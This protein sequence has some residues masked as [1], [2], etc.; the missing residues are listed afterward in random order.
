MVTDAFFC[1]SV[2]L[3]LL[4]LQPVHAANQTFHVQ[5][6]WEPVHVANQTFH[7][8]GLWEP[9]QPVNQTFLV[10][11]GGGTPR[12]RRSPTPRRRRSETSRRRRTSGCQGPYKHHIH[13]HVH[14]ILSK[15]AHKGVTNKNA[16]DTL[17]DISF[18]FGSRGIPEPRG[19]VRYYNDG[20]I[21]MNH[22]S[23]S[24]WGDYLQC[25]HPDGSTT[26]SCKCPKDHK[27][28]CDMKRAGK[29]QNSH[30]DGHLWYSFPNAG[31]G[32]YW[33][34]E[35]GSGCKAIRVTAKCVIDRLATEA[36][37]PGK[38]STKT[39]TACVTCV[40]K[41]SDK[42]KEHVWDE[43]VFGGKCKHVGASAPPGYNVSANVSVLAANIIV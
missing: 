19:V 43:S 36:G 26:Y 22:M 11:K 39:A 34:Y 40:N 30:S 6:L 1:K 32:T 9:V 13:L 8:Q 14:H 7:V 35:H 42:K 24:S 2:G 4:C 23:V 16:A 10:Q 12:R 31:K 33:D 37:C 17:G 28:S 38:C 15:S 27:G 25:N 41:L 20:V 3:I 29:Q 21:E 18:I 5:D